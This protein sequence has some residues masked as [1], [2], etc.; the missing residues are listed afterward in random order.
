AY[1]SIPNTTIDS[2]QAGYVVQVKGEPDSEFNQVHVMNLHSD[3]EIREFQRNNV[4]HTNYVHLNPILPSPL[5]TMSSSFM[6]HVQSAIQSAFLELDFEI[7]TAIQIS[8]HTV[9]QMT[10]TGLKYMRLCNEI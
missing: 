5:T 4:V 10:P 3:K 7:G 6:S 8:S 1:V 2:Q 9:L